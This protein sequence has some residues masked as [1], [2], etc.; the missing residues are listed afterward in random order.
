LVRG[1]EATARQAVERDFDPA[2][3]DIPKPVTEVNGM[4]AYETSVSEVDPLV[5]RLRKTSPKVTGGLLR[6]REAAYAAG[7]FPA[8]VKVLTA[9][10]LSVAIR[11]EPC[12]EMYA[13]RAAE[14][15]V[16]FEEL[17]EF[18][19][20]A[21]AM[22]GCPGEAWALKAV[23]AFTSLEERRTAPSSVGEDES[24]CR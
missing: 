12:I 22:Q 10:T 15:G 18:L 2:P 21:M 20:I 17:V 16:V 11:C 3:G 4:E 14:E 5:V 13:K 23:K 7:I 6:V 24:C 1:G 9:L 19:N 8:K